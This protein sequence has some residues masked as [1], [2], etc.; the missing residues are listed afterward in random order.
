MSQTLVIQEKF[1]NSLNK[2]NNIAVLRARGYATAEMFMQ[3]IIDRLNDEF[4]FLEITSYRFPLTKNESSQFSQYG[5]FVDGDNLQYEK[6]VIFFTPIVSKSGDVIIEQSLMPTICTQMEENLTF[7]LD[8]RIKKITLLTSKIN[9]K[10]EVSAYYN[11]TQM[12]VNSLNTLNIDV[13]PFFPIKN[14]STDTKFNTLVEYLEMSD[15]LQEKNVSN[16]QNKNLLIYN[17]TT[18]C[19]D[20]EL[21]QLKGEFPKSFCFRFLTA[22]L[23]G[24]NDYK[25]SISNI[26]NKLNNQLDNQFTNLKNF[27]DYVN[28]NVI[29]QV[30]FIVP[31]NEDTIESDDDIENIDNIHRMPEKGLDHT[32]RKRYKTQKKIRDAVLESAKYLCNCNDLKH[33]YFEATDLHNYVEGHHIVPMNRQEEYYFDKTV[34]LD[35]SQN[36]VALCPNC[37]C[38]IHLGS[39][40]ARLKILSEILVRN[41]AQLISFAPNLTLSLLASYYNIGLENNSEEE[42]DWLRRAEKTIKDKKNKI[43]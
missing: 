34:N 13:I 42:K 43:I 28:I 38:Q 2:G 20:C 21:T 9:A 6:V 33:F 15:F 35:I 1:Y 32:G 19:G 26:I 16:S 14:L 23:V 4:S 5:A 24:G 40:Q 7:L 41:K 8:E 17:K 18:V 39:R 3:A 30:H 27:I 37:H 29:K 36:I 31:A 12:D 10:N 22:I 11:K 25:Y